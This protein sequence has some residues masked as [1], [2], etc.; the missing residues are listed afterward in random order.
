MLE[1]LCSFLEA[2]RVNPIPCLFP[3]TEAS[4][5][6]G[7]MPP[8]FISAHSSIVTCPSHALL[9]F[10]PLPPLR[11]LVTIWRSTQILQDNLPISGPYI[12]HICKV[13]FA[14]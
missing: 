4:C 2:L 13:S 5:I 11:I 6:P 7:L 8:S 3:F 12:N 10:P 14:M 9:V 1:E